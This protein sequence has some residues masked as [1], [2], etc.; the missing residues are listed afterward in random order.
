MYSCYTQLRSYAFINI[1]SGHFEFDLSCAS[2]V[3]SDCPPHVKINLMVQKFYAFMKKCTFQPV[4]Q[5]KLLYYDGQSV[6][7]FFIVSGV[8]SPKSSNVTFIAL[9]FITLIYIFT[10]TS[11]YFLLHNYISLMASVLIFCAEECSVLKL[12][13]IFQIVGSDKL[14]NPCI[15]CEPFYIVACAEKSI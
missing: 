9:Q 12:L 2:R 7:V 6:S 10:F 11:L 5:T 13:K 14:T 1:S 3:R 4:Q 8:S 15:S